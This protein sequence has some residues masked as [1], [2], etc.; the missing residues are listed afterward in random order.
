MEL[1]LW[2]WFYDPRWFFNFKIS[3]ICYKNAWLFPFGLHILCVFIC[4]YYLQI[5]EV[6]AC[7]SSL[8]LWL[9][10]RAFFSTL[11]SATIFFFM[12]KIVQVYEKEISFFDNAKKIYPVLKFSMKQY[13]YWIRRKSLIS[14][15][16]IILL[17]LGVISLF[18]SYL[19]VS[20]YSIQNLYDNCDIK[21]IKL[22]SFHSLLIFLGNLPLMIVILILL[23]VKLS[24]LVTAFLCP[25]FLI[26]ISKIG[27]RKLKNDKENSLCYK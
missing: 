24:S 3:I 12:K 17:I 27:V 20:F 10:S 7:D 6:S 16:G 13:D 18:W 14:T 11:I 23:V 5:A 26:S 8:R 22:L 15:P 9:A 4:L 2:L 1:L 19:I 25:E 21:I